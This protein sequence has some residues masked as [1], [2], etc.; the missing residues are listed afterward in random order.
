[1]DIRE[2]ERHEEKDHKE[3]RIFEDIRSSTTG[4]KGGRWV[5]QVV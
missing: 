1:M 4:Q 2:Q 5:G 3:L